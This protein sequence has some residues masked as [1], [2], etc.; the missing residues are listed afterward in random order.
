MITS[1]TS[2]AWV[3]PP[4]QVTRNSSARQM[5]A[6]DGVGELMESVGR[7]YDAAMRDLPTP[8]KRLTTAAQIMTQLAELA[9]KS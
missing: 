8:E 9:R 7:A 6:A 3:A 4:S 2:T 5:P 1:P